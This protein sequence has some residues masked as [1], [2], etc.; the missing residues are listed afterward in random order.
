MFKRK[1]SVGTLASCAVV[2][3]GVLLASAADIHANVWGTFLA[4]ACM[5][6]TAQYQL[7]V[8]QKR[9]ELDATPMQLLAAATPWAAAIAMIAIPFVE[10]SGLFSPPLLAVTPHRDLTTEGF[11]GEVLR[12]GAD[13]AQVALR[14]AARTEGEEVEGSLSIADIDAEA[15][16]GMGP[17]LMSFHFTGEVMSLL[18]LSAIMAVGVNLSVFL[19]IGATDAV[20]STVVGHLKTVAVLVGAFF[21]FGYPLSP[22]NLGGIALAIAGMAAYTFYRRAANAAAKARLL[23]RKKAKKGKGKEKKKKKGTG[24]V[25]S[26]TGAGATQVEEAVAGEMGE[27]I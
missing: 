12:S 8:E 21:L 10:P 26:G 7:L 4:V 23:A 9:K 27:G 6:T 3:T 11:E 14:E 20:T 13:L 22:V 1:F 18:L 25:G 19:L 15:G 16:R 24:T 5:V 17:S 2:V